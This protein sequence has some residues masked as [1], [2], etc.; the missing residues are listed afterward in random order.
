MVKLADFSTTKEIQTVVAS[1]A[2]KP[3]HRADEW[4]NETTRLL[5]KKH[6]A[7]AYKEGPNLLANAGFETAGADGLPEGWK[8]R[9]YAGRPA[10]SGAEWAMVS[11]ADQFHGGKLGV[12]CITRGEADTSLY[13]DV[14]LKPNTMYRLSGWVKARGGLRGKISLNDHLGRAETDRVTRDGD[15]TF[16]E[17]DYNSGKTTKTSVNLLHVA[18]GD[19]YFDDVKVC[20]LISVDDEAS[21]NVVGDS[22]RGDQIFHKHVAACVLCH[23]LKGQ[24][25]TVGP[26]LDG[27][28][29]RG[30]AAYIRE[31]LLEPS[32][33]MAKGFEGTGLSPMPPMSDIF[34][35]QELADV[36]AFLQTLK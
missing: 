3:E 22:K 26:A 11:G 32:K 9:D 35:A 6:K 14:E 30:T 33:V 8:R 15:W 4:L 7:E 13:A 31:S 34:N 36:Q 12:R 16:V 18:K 25:S 20:E 27:I 24:G 2:R 19:G 17:V 1:L 23:Q 10:N 21:Q 29:T 28:A 5:T